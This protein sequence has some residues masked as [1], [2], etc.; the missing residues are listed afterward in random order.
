MG[1][2]R[3]LSILWTSADPEVA[4]RM[5]FLYALNAARRELWEEIR[6]IVWGPSAKCLAEDTGLQVEA[7]ALAQAGV[8]LEA[9]VACATEYGVS[10]KLTAIG[11]DVKPMG[12][13]LT[14]RL[15]GDWTVLT[16]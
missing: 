8:V 6:L 11:C 2:A 4:Y 14:E 15:Q 16:F 3:K 10:E 1:S 5:I 9:C 12:Q 7:Q 13:P